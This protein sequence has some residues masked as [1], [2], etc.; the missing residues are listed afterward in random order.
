MTLVVGRPAEPLPAQAMLIRPDG[1]FAWADTPEQP[2]TTVSNTRCDT[3]SAL[4]SQRQNDPAQRPPKGC[5]PGA[6]TGSRLVEKHRP[7]RN[8]RRWATRG[9]IRDR[10]TVKVWKPSIA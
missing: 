7:D 10:G 5:R 2:D 4:I 6:E 9:F 8:F 1:F 3:G